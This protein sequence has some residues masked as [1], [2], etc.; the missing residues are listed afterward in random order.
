[1]NSHFHSSQVVQLTGIT[2]RQLQWWDEQGIVVPAREGHCRLYS[3]ADLAEVAVICQLR[4]KGFSLQRVRKVMRL[5]QKNFAT[6]LAA[7][8]C[9]KSTYHLLTDGERVYLETSPR[10]IVDILKNAQQPI[11]AVCVSDEVRRIRATLRTNQSNRKAP[12]R[13]TP[14]SGAARQLA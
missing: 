6:R 9:G 10:E 1:M 13:S 11:L 14:R 5:L 8:V 12:A 7:T 4:K 2:P 3:Q